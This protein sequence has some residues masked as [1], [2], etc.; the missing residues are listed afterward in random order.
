MQNK[1]SFPKIDHLREF[2]GLKRIENPPTGVPR[3]NINNE[4]YYSVTQILDNGKFAKIDPKNLLHS[5][6]LGSIV[7]LQIE[8]H[9]KNKDLHFGLEETLDENQL[10]LFHFLPEPDELQ[11]EWDLYL[12]S[13]SDPNNT[14]EELVLK[15]RISTAY[16]HFNKFL[17]EHEVIPIWSEEIIWNPS[18]L[19]AGTVDLLC[20]LDGKLT[21]IDH[22]TSRFI[23]DSLT[24]LD[25]Y[26]G[27]L[28]AYTKAINTLEGNEY[29]IDLKLLHLDPLGDNYK[30]IPRKYNFEVFLNALVRFSQAKFLPEDENILDAQNHTVIEI[31]EKFKTKKYP[32]PNKSCKED[33]I[34]PFPIDNR[35]LIDNQVKDIVKVAWHETHN[36]FAVFHINVTNLEVEKSF[37][38]IGKT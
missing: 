25:N 4:G 13:P 17:E 15:K 37:N 24:S 31:D 1:V 27:Q 23:D 16:G 35:F 11:E 10:K 22:K 34:F 20:F 26:T 9:F 29:D 32:C 3:Y 14:I 28:S 36:H 30:L 38:Q 18:Y 5:Q 33:S 7:H 21:I 8:N 12:Q 6:T 2:G 19:Y